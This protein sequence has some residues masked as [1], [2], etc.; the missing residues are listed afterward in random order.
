MA[1]EPRFRDD[2]YRGTAAYYDEFRVPYPRALTEDVLARVGSTA[3]NRLFDL[4]CGTGQITF[5]L[6]D[7][8]AEVWAVD[9]E[10]E[11]VAFVRDKASRLGVENVQWFAQRAELVEADS[12]F[13]LVTAGNSFHRLARERVAACAMRWLAPGGHIALVW[14]DTPWIGPEPWQQALNE[15]SLE[16][17]DRLSARDRVPA[18]LEAHMTER[19]NP[20]V[21]RDAGFEIVGRY[22]FEEPYD[23]SV[24]SLIGWAYSTSLL[25][26]AVVGE[27]RDVFER[28]MDERLRAVEPS[29]VFRQAITASYDLARRP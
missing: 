28:D 2:L 27:H 11:T 6:C 12:F 25:P 26:P 22:D 24:E 8:F 19:P 5:A 29:G 1:D 21:L 3:P 18:S 15:V 7:H 20:D 14:S 4:G 16:W 10:P 23:W 9:L 13:S 17:L